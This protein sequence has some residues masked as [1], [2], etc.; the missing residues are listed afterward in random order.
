MQRKKYALSLFLP[1]SIFRLDRGLETL[2]FFLNQRLAFS[3]LHYNSYKQFFI[4]LLSTLLRSEV[5]DTDYYGS[6]GM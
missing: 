3:V 4:L 6:V 2:D 1:P 5:E